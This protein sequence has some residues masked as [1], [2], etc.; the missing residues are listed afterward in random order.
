MSAFA[1]PK[2]CTLACSFSRLLLCFAVMSLCPN[3]R[4]GRWETHLGQ[5]GEIIHLVQ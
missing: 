4:F 3:L 2:F 5:L 1:A